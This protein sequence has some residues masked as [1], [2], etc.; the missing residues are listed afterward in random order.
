MNDVA[1]PK[2]QPFLKD[3]MGT[4]FTFYIWG[5]SKGQKAKLLNAMVIPTNFKTYLILDPVDFIL[6]FAFT[7]DGLNAPPPPNRAR[8]WLKSY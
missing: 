8:N 4:P 7:I 5:L 1:S 3:H 2:E 6:D